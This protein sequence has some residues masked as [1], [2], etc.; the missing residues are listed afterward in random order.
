MRVDEIQATPSFINSHP[1]F[2]N[3]NFLLFRLIG[4]HVDVQYVVDFAPELYE[5]ITETKYMEQL[6]FHVPELARNVS[7][8]VGGVF[9]YL[10][11]IAPPSI[12]W[13][14][15]VGVLGEGATQHHVKFKRK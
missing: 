12:P 1:G 9:R 10:L 3:E 6:G 7:L 4:S 2:V 5:I 13:G 15:A 8:Q 11:K 14:C